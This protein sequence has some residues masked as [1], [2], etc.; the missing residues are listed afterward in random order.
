MKKSEYKIKLEINLDPFLLFKE[1]Y[2][3][4]VAEGIKSAAL[5]YVNQLT[6]LSQK[7]CNREVIK[8]KVIIEH[9]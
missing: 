2:K 9:I 5:D 6:S 4:A 1:D 7:E 8:M 3:N